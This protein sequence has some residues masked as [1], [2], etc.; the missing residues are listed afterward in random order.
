MSKLLLKR[1]I[2]DEKYTP[3]KVYFCAA[4]NEKQFI[5]AC[6]TSLLKKLKERLI[7]VVYLFDRRFGVYIAFALEP[8]AS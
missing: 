4:N 6:I 7:S 3:L 2:Y 8:A 5:F 1:Y